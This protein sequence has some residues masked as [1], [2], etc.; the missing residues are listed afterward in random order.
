M[1]PPHGNRLHLSPDAL[2]VEADDLLFVCGPHRPH[3]QPLTVVNLGQI[4]EQELSLGVVGYHGP[5]VGAKVALSE[6]DDQGVD[7]LCFH[8]LLAREGIVP[9]PVGQLFSTAVGQ[10]EDVAVLPDGDNVTGVVARG[11]TLYIRVGHAHDATVVVLLGRPVVHSGEDHHGAGVFLKI[12]AEALHQ[13][14]GQ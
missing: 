10:P 11:P 2:D 9:A 7:L 12:S 5:Q 4:G 6:G 3:R 13:V 14:A 1:C 8:Q